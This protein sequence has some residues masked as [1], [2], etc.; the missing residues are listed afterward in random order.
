MVASL[1]D[2]GEARAINR[3]GETFSAERVRHLNDAQEQ[4]Y[5]PSGEVATRLDA[6]NADMQRETYLQLLP[7]YVWRFVEKSAR[8]LDLE[9]RGDLGGTFT[10][11]PRR[12]G[13]LDSLLPALA[14]YPSSLRGRLCVYRPDA[15]EDGIWLHPGEPVFDAL[16]YE[17]LARFGADALRGGIF[18]DPV[19]ERPYLFHLAIVS[20][21]LGSDLSTDGAGTVPRPLERRLI[22]VRQDE[23]GVPE[24]SDVEPLLL[25]RGDPQTPPGAVPLASRGIGMRAEATNHLRR[26]GQRHLVDERKAAARR[27]LPE[28]LQRVAAGF[29]LRSAELAR[30][31]TRLTSTANQSVEVKKELDTVKQTQRALAA[32]RAAVLEGTEAAPRHIR[33]GE[34]E[35]VA[36]ALAIPPT[37]TEA[38]N[39]ERLRHDET[40]EAMAVRI[41][42]AWETDRGA[43][44]VDVS[45]PSLAR[46]AGLPDHPGFDLR[47]VTPDGE[48][49][50]IE[51]KGRSGRDSI[52]VEVNEWK[53][54]CNLGEQYWLYV[55]FDCATPRPVLVRVQDPFAKLLAT[56]RQSAAFVIS[57]KDVIDAG[58]ME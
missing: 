42:S 40:V 58:T 22:A 49:R 15:D 30:L 44:V 16:A 47:A 14:T 19:A 37:S 52:Q 54:A 35:F 18:V 53:Q 26:W 41:A 5:G 34:V 57:A 20:A 43:E 56:M 45:K 10:L 55:V 3:I 7:G 29:D 13:A 33:S 4:I 24:T 17:V 1:T 25:L 8:L 27:E 50:S 23:A 46:V 21:E 2:D 32:E 12:S 31:R 39:N 11:V 48:S 36:H 9:I 6:L 51:V 28:R 38:E